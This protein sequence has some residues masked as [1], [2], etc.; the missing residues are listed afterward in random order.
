MNYSC[1]GEV[2][3]GSFGQQVLQSE[4]PVLLVIGANGAEADQEALLKEWIPQAGGRL[5]ICR[6]AA[7]R[8]TGVAALSNMP[9]GPGLALFS[10]GALCYQFVGRASPRDLDEA[11]ARANALVPNQDLKN[12]ASSQHQYEHTLRSESQAPERN[13]S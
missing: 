1:I 12:P 8:L 6:I 3:E 13:R 2:N 9:P 7:E 11:L 10:Q 5:K 4:L